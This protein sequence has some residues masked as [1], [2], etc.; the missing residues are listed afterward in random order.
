M[1]LWLGFC[2]N[3][4]STNQIFLGLILRKFWLY[5]AGLLPQCSRMQQ[6]SDH[7]QGWQGSILKPIGDRWSN[8]PIYMLVILSLILHCGTIIFNSHV[9]FTLNIFPLLF[10]KHRST[11]FTLSHIPCR[12]WRSIVYVHSSLGHMCCSSSSSPKTTIQMQ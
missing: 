7:I 12:E 3:K 4:I 11:V 5:Y 2:T 9:G 1:S 6:E 8:P 10:I